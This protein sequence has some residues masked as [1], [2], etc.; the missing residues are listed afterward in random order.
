MGN[1]EVEQDFEVACDFRDNTLYCKITT[2]EKEVLFAFYISVNGKIIDKLWYSEKNS[3]AYDLGE[4]RV[5][6]YKVIF[7][8]KNN[9]GQ[10]K[11]KSLERRSHWSVCN[12]ILTAVSL[13]TEKSDSLLEFGSGYG[14][15]LLSDYCKVTSIE[16]N[17]DFLGLY[18]EVSYIST[19]I[20]ELES[21]NQTSPSC[22][23]Y[24]F[25]PISDKLAASY[26]IL[27]VDGPPADVGREGLLFHLDHF[28][29]IPVWIV[30]DVLREKDQR[31]ANIICLE[32]G[33]IQYRFWNFS[34]LT[35]KPIPSKIL[36]KIH[37][38]SLEV[39]SSQSKEYV[40]RYYTL[41]KRGD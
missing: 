28:S 7:F 26:S 27:L 3:I 16:H 37:S 30:D 25:K 2:L 14:S 23:W 11:S 33:L 13:L 10:M 9:L 41:E 6:D 31:I 17:D 21:E 18:P 24:D 20:V 5:N 34:L 32:L 35:K 36:E 8:I 22:R 1:Q 40:Q 15:K 29:S 38:K 12:G 19:K 39:L 4:R